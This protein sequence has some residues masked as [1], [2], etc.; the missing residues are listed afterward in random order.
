M[1]KA[2][3]DLGIE[4]PGTPTGSVSISAGVA[5]M[6][7]EPGQR[8]DDL[9]KAADEAL[10]Y[11]KAAGRNCVVFRHAGEYVTYEESEQDLSA[12]NV[13]NLLASQRNAKA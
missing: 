4:H 12:T 11:A 2:I 7:P 5:A 1:R 8:A 9:I 6:I 3:L 10:Y 13:I